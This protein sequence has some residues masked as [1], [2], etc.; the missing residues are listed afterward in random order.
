MSQFISFL[1]GFLFSIC[2]KTMNRAKNLY[3]EYTENERRDKQNERRETMSKW[4]SEIRKKE[5]KYERERDLR[6][7]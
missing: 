5:G 3:G 1:G 6:V 2:L 4:M 7:I